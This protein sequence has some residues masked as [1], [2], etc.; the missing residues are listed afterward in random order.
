MCAHSKSRSQTSSPPAIRARVYLCRGGEGAAGSNFLVQLWFKCSRMGNT[1]SKNLRVLRS[2]R[3]RLQTNVC[4][5]QVYG[6][7]YA[8]LFLMY[9]TFCSRFRRLYQMMFLLPNELCPCCRRCSR[10]PGRKQGAGRP[11][12]ATQRLPGHLTR[13]NAAFTES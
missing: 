3:A 7:V 6:G 11:L 13:S 1:R 10:L 2:V 12:A 4:S 8:G 5:L 9:K